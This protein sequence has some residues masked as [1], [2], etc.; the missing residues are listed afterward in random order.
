[1]KHWDC[2]D[3]QPLVMVDDFLQIYSGQSNCPD[4]IKEFITL[5]STT[6]YRL[7]M[8]HL[9]Q[10]GKKF[11]SP[12][13]L[14]STNWERLDHPLT[15]FITFPE[16]AKRRYTQFEI[17]KDHKGRVSLFSVHD[18]LPNESGNISSSKEE[19][20]T[21]LS[22]VVDYLLQ[23]F[24]KEWRRKS[25]FYRHVGMGDGDQP[26][27]QVIGFSEDRL[28]HLSVVYPEKPV[29][30]PVVMAHAIPEPLKVR[31]ITKGH[32]HC[33]VLK[34]LQKAMFQAMD[35]FPCFKPC[36]TPDYRSDLEEIYKNSPSSHFWVSGDYSSATDKMHQDVM[37]S[38]ME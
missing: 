22:R 4:E 20:A 30:T 31:M 24:L 10:K 8:A 26:I 25:N 32:P 14:Y 36:F 15:K 28:S 29:D 37:I 7:P 34:P 1:M 38:V 35:Q 21:K 5:N 17:K 13:I 23:F 2:Y 19:V 33:H 11:T 27:E 16:A 9:S 12:L 18:G 6:D 3:D